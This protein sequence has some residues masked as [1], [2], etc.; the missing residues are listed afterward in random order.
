MW[1][2]EWEWEESE[3]RTE[4]TQKKSIMF[5]DV[6]AR[7]CT[8]LHCCAHRMHGWRTVCTRTSVVSLTRH[9]ACL[10]VWMLLCYTLSLG[11]RCAEGAAGAWCGVRGSFFSSFEITPDGGVWRCWCMRIRVFKR[12]LFLTCFHG[13]SM[14]Q[15][16]HRIKIIIF[17]QT[18]SATSH[19]RWWVCCAEMLIDPVKS[20]WLPLESQM[21]FL[22]QKSDDIEYRINASWIFDISTL[23]HVY[24]GFW[25]ILFPPSANGAKNTFWFGNSIFWF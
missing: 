1:G 11:L 23:F 16:G 6:Y 3:K 14:P 12:K 5:I 15:S 18:E 2:S 7:L 24:M 4:E 25:I 13:A 10:L 21:R 8:A 20:I 19:S 17:V 9:Y 22:V